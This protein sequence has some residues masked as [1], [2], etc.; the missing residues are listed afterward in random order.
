MATGDTQR[1]TDSG[2]EVRRCYDA[3]DLGGFDPRTELG[4]PGAYPYTAEC[5]A[6]CT[7]AGCG[8]CASTP[9]SGRPSS[10]NERFKFLLGAGQTGLSSRSTSPPRWDTTRTTRVAEG[11]VGKVGV[12]IDSIEDMRALVG[13]AAPRQ[14]VDFD[15]DQRH[16]RDPVA[17]I[18]ARGRGGGRRAV[19]DQRHDPERH[20]QGVRRPRHLHLPAPAVHASCHRH[21]RLLRGADPGMEHDLD[22]RLPHP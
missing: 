14:G 8:P 11:E 12:A 22:L 2:I 5:S 13:R 1:R 3:A 7:A 10:T 6:T 4:E 20:P 9:G 21:L 17:S 18:R 16:R 15:D 19:V